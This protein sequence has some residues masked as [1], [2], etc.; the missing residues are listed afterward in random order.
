MPDEEALLHRPRG[1]QRRW[2]LRYRP[3]NPE[4]DAQIGRLAA[5]A[6]L[7]EV[8]ARLLYVRGC[9]TAEEAGRF[10][11]MESSQL[12]DPFLLTDMQKAVERLD[13]ALR[14]GEKIAVYGDYDVDGVTSV[15]LL[16]LYLTG[17]GADVS[18]YIPSRSGEGYG[19]ST[20]ALDRLHAGGAR[21]IVTVDTG[22]SAVREA[23]YAAGLGMDLI[24][25]DHHEC[26]SE[27]PDACAVINPHRPGDRY[28]YR[29]L[30]G[31]GVAFKLVC[32]YEML[33]C[34]RAGTPE[35]DGVR[36]VCRRY[37]D[38]VTLGTIADVM[39]VTDENRL[40]IA[41]GL[42]RMGEDCRLGLYEL[43]AAAAGPGRPVP[44]FSSTHIGYVLAPRI[45]AA[46]RVSHASLAVELLLTDSRARARELAARLCALNA[47]RQAEETRI[48]QE[49]CR[50][51]ELLPA[52]EREGVLVLDDDSWHPG[53]IGIV[54]SRVTERYGLPSILISYGRDGEENAPASPEDVGRGSGRSVPG[55]NLAEAL[56]DCRDLLVRFGGHELAAGPS[57]R[58]GEVGEFRRRIQ[59]YAAARMTEEMR[60][61]TL[62]ADC[63]LEAGRLTLELAQALERLEPFGVSNPV[64]CFVLRDA[65]LTRVS[66][67]GGGRHMRLTLEKDGR[68]LTAVWFGHSPD[69]LPF[70]A[71]DGVDLL[72]QLGVNEY[73]GRVSLQLVVQDAM[74]A[75][76]VRARC[77]RE[78]RRYEELCAGA[79]YPA[80]E[81]V[82]PA[83]ADMAAVYT[84]V[85]R[86]AQAGHGSFSAARLMEA[87]RT[88][89]G[90]AL[91]YSKL[92]FVLRILRELR[93]CGVSEPEPDVFR[94]EID[95]AVRTDLE[96]SDILHRLRSQQIR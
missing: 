17:L 92:R 77:E 79:A 43:A 63:E 66:P 13:R 60:A 20:A 59:A 5:E 21:L 71:G 76:A 23:A 85:R 39:P 49:V 1:R 47:A 11:R 48:M 35:A 96:T 34:R 3:G 75:A 12:Y 26:L 78:V 55:L 80:S 84:F 38:L 8:L 87:V 91:G 44:H 69:C 16:C 65:L 40:I 86:E 81:D 45:N 68:T 42:R 22:V 88:A 19:L 14:E 73:Q 15:S 30:A 51:V 52:G 82:L 54:A 56:A 95:P 46:G 93:V 90:G 37:A 4:A 72:F 27:L 61:V 33:R 58:R 9:R 41:L 31:V 94:F 7:P 83:R 6:D 24:V 25:T 50:R 70:A 2:T 10:F 89:D 28:P 36:D 62:E 67:M 57:I 74:P 18:Y 64:P 32:A 53:I 29:T